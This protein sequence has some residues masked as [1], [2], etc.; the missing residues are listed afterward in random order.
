MESASGE[1]GE[2]FRLDGQVAVVT[3]AGRGIGREVARMLARAGATVALCARTSSDLD[4]V[5]ET[6]EED[7]GVA[8][9]APLDITDLPSVRRCINEVAE[10]FGHLEILVNSAG[11]S[12]LEDALTTTE[13]DWDRVHN[14]NV[15]GPFFA[16]QAVGSLMVKG[17]YG[18]IVNV[19]SMGGSVGWRRC[20]AYCASKGG[21][22]QMSRVLALEWAA[23]GV[24]V[25]AVAPGFVESSM[26]AKRMQD[27]RYLDA[28]LSRVPVGRVGLPTE[29]AAAVLY[30]V[31]REAGMTTGSVLT[32]DGGWTAE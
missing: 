2:P 4:A 17:G 15:K 18:R 14:V 6:I 9:P 28:V 26:T 32:V 27:R 24:T 20:A 31:S 8:H 21:V 23:S 3:G 5:A 7:G 1:L 22:E 25:N 10:R 12:H 29:V 11:V 30:L 16:C 13:T 19:S